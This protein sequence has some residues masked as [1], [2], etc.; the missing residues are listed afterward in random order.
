MNNFIATLYICEITNVDIDANIL[1]MIPEDRRNRIMQAVK[2]EKAK[3][4][5]IASLLLGFVLS[6]YDK[7]FEDIK[8]TKNGKPYVEFGPCFN[9]SHS[10]KYVVVAI[11]NKEI[12]V[13]IQKKILISNA[14]AKSFLCIEENV[15]LPLEDKYYQTYIWCRKEALLKCLGT[16]WNKEDV[17]EISVLDSKIE[18]NGIKYYLTDYAILENY[19]L[20]L[21]EKDIHKEFSIREVSKCEL[22]LF[23]R[24]NKRID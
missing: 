4:L 7:A 24:T 22:E 20:T 13:D 15:I 9:V 3:Q 16:G 17:S 12:G 11:A 1:G 5:Y 21:C 8:T 18:Y 23:Y 2:H 10:G 19:F 14:I 6:Q